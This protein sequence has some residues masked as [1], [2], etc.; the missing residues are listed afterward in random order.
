MNFSGRR[1]RLGVAALA[2]ST[3][4]EI[5]LKIA[6]SRSCAHFDVPATPG[7][8]SARSSSSGKVPSISS[9]GLKPSEKSRSKVAP[10][11]KFSR[12]AAV[13]AALILG[14]GSSP[15]AAKKNAFYRGI[16]RSRDLDIFSKKKP[17]GK[18]FM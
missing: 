5:F 11:P 12:S 16:L 18:S 15:R 4:L 6:K 14:G 7:I 9:E 13:A 8:A 3:V 2:Q 17:D 1:S 10:R